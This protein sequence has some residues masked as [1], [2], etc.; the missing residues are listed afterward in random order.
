MPSRFSI[1][2][3]TVVMLVVLRLTIGWHFF[4]EGVKHYVDPHWTSEPV[5]K[6]SKGPLAPNFHAYLPDFHGFDELLHGGPVQDESHA[7]EA[8][9]SRVQEDWEQ[10]RQA[11][12]RHFGMSEEQQARTVKTL[13]EYQ[14]RLRDWAA[15]NREDLIN[16]IH[17]WQRMAS[18]RDSR[19]ATCRFKRLA[20]SQKQATLAGEA[21]SWLAEV[22]GLERGFFDDLETGLSDD[23][24]A[25]PAF[26]ERPLPIERV[27]RTYDLCYSGIGLLLILGLFTR[28]ACLAGAAFLLSVVMM[29][30]FWVSDAAPTYQSMPS[31]CSRC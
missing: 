3:A 27:D 17:Q 13:K 19:P 25:R 24:R 1:G 14:A 11:F 2:M 28:L 15:A 10:A 12:V 22:K 29:Q 6:A 20:W 16:H 7:L 8:W 4:S 31:K 26:A 5:L 23:Q 21:S 30:P 18:T 9:T